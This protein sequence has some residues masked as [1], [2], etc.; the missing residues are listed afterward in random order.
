MSIKIVTHTGQA[1]RDEFMA[2]C[3]IVATHEGCRI[4]RRSVRPEDLLDP[5]TLV[6]DQGMEH[7]PNLYNFDHHQFERDAPAAC[8]ITLILE[9]VGVED[10][11]A[12]R[13]IWQW[14]E[15][16]EWLDA[17]G[18]YQTAE[19]FK[20][21]PDTLI[22]SMSP[23]ETSVLRWFAS[24]KVVQ[25]D[26]E[27]WQ[28]M[29]RIGSDKL[30]YYNQVSERLERLE[31]EVVF[32]DLYSYKVC[33]ATSIDRTEGPLL[34]LE[35]YLRQLNLDCPITV[36]QDDRG[37]GLCLFRRGNDIRTDFSKVE[38]DDGVVFAHKNGYVAKLHADV[39]WQG[40]LEASQVKFLAPK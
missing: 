29:H 3:L 32:H 40:I 23:V 34:A 9:L 12:A 25:P 5:A 1:H 30:D 14:L 6:L 4:E 22:N 38:N 8:S 17:K 13:K 36:T 18:P 28:L 20:M 35:L 11:D 24:K 39:P 19:R 26:H 27:L 10:A 7:D 33:D 21:D 31:R 37:D 16:S 15:F 2:C